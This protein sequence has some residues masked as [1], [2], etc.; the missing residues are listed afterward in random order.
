MLRKMVLIHRILCK[1]VPLEIDG[2][3]VPMLYASNSRTT[4]EHRAFNFLLDDKI[5]KFASVVR[6]TGI[7]ISLFEQ[8]DIPL[9]VE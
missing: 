3:F 1:S 5:M 6:A 4:V 8:C 9:N 2:T 7:S